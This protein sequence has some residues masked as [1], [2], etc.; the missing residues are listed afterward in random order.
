MLTVLPHRCE[1]NCKHQKSEVNGLPKQRIMT[2]D[3]IKCWSHTGPYPTEDSYISVVI[4]S[5]CYQD[6][7]HA[8]VDQDKHREKSR[9][10]YR[11]R[12]PPKGSPS[13]HDV[14][15]PEIA[16]PKP[17]SINPNIQYYQQSPPQSKPKVQLP[18]ESPTAKLLTYKVMDPFEN[19]YLVTKQQA[20]AITN[21][22]DPVQVNNGKTTW[23]F[24]APRTK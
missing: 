10:F 3:D 24:N 22:T 21:Q 14:P 16:T 18:P 9:E 19:E 20:Q 15:I 13:P 1:E 7:L 12:H 23:I 11:S 8:I 17:S 5:T 6:L 2:F 4:P